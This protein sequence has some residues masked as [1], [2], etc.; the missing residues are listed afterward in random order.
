MEDEMKLGHRANEAW[1]TSFSTGELENL[2]IG[3]AVDP[4]FEAK[5]AVLNSAIQQIGMGK[6]QWKLFALCGFGWVFPPIRS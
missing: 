4:I 6:Y 3:G 1:T 2:K 5:A